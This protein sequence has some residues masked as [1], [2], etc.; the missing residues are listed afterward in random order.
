MAMKTPAYVGAVVGVIAL[1]I[2]AVY[3]DGGRRLRRATSS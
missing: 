2:V 1:I 3:A